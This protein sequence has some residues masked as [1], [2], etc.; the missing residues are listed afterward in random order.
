MKL[1]WVV[2]SCLPGALLV[3]AALVTCYGCPSDDNG[4]L[5]E[6]SGQHQTAVCDKDWRRCKGAALEGCYSGGLVT[7]EALVGI[8]DCAQTEL[9]N[10]QSQWAHC[11][12]SRGTI[13]GVRE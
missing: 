13:E 9:A 4:D 10:C 5:L 3:T 8:A 2:A 12:R 11:L 1:R 7:E 6:L